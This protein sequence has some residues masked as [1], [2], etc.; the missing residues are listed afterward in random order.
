MPSRQEAHEDLDKR[1][2][3]A[4]LA[5]LAV[6][7]KYDQTAKPSSGAI[8]A[9]VKKEL[10]QLA[11]AAGQDRGWINEVHERM[12]ALTAAELKAFRLVGT[13]MTNKEIAGALF[14]QPDT[15]RTHIKRIHDKLDIKGRARLALAAFQVM[16]LEKDKER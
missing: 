10:G 5:L 16:E 3:E 9:I 1:L 7:R 4:L 15:L 2:G 12:T 8:Q 13:G 6:F 14:I 11:A